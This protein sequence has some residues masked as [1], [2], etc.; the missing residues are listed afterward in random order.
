[1]VMDHQSYMLLHY[2]DEKPRYY[3]RNNK[4]FRYEHGKVC[5]RDN[6]I[7]SVAFVFRVVKSYYKYDKLTNRMSV[8]S[9]SFTKAQIRSNANREK[10][11]KSCTESV[12]FLKLVASKY[13][14]VTK[15]YLK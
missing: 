6:D 2:L 8:N 5:V 7:F 9:L 15:L 12:S 11:Y 10:V 1:M 3:M 13:K 14:R 4:I